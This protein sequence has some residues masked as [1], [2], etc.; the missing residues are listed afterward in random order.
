MCVCICVCVYI[1]LY[2]YN[3]NSNFES[4]RIQ[5]CEFVFDS[6][7][8]ILF[9]F[10]SKRIRIPKSRIR[11]LE[12]RIELSRIS[13]FSNSKRILNTPIVVYQRIPLNPL[14]ISYRILNYWWI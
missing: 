7:S 3:L 12:N 10:E 5:N 14:K 4:N 6:N 1:Y 11:I 2:I 13:N 8:I 9:E